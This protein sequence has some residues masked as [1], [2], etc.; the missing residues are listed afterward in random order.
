MWFGDEDL[1]E[2]RSGE[3]CSLLF[4]NIREVEIKEVEKC[5]AVSSCKAAVGKHASEM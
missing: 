4:W 2:S 3:V 5:V 1:Y